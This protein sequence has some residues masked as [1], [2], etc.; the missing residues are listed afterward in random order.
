MKQILNDFLTL[1]L[2]EGDHGWGAIIGMIYIC[3]AF[4]CALSESF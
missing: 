4:D 2:G 1:F 3:Y